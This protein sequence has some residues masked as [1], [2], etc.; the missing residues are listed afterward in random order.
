MSI[1]LSGILLFLIIRAVVFT[2]I[3]RKERRR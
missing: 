1:I 2:A 3:V